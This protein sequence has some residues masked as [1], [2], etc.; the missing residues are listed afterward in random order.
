MTA[1][2]S[3]LD[4]IGERTSSERAPAV[5]AFAEAFL[6]RLSADGGADG[7]KADALCGAIVGAFEFASARGAEPIAV[8]AFT[9][10]LEEHGYELPGSVV[11]TNTE[12]WPFLVDSVSAELRA[13]GLGHPPRAAP[14][15]R[16]RA[17]RRR[18]DRRRPAPARG[19]ASRV[20]H[21]LRARAAAHGRAAG[22]GRGGAA[23]GPLRRP[24]DGQG[25]PGDGRP[26]AADGPA[27][28]RRR[29]ALRRR[30]GRRDRRLPRVAAARQLHLPRLPRVPDPRGRDL[31]RARF[32]PRDPLQHG[33]VHVRE[34]AG[35]R[36]AAARGA[37]AGGRGRPADRLQD[38]PALARPPPRA[39]GL[40]RRAPHL[41][42]GR[43]RRRGADARPVHHQ[44]LRRAGQPDAAAAPQAAPDPA[45]RGPDRGL[46]RLQGRGLAVRLVPQGRA[47]RRLD[48]RPARR[49]RRAARAAGRAGAAARPPRPRLPQRVA[50]RRA[51]A[52]ALQPR[53]AGAAAGPAA[54][55][56]R[57]RRGRLPHGAGGGRPRADPL[58]RPRL[59]GPAR[60]R[61]PRARA[62]GR[63]DDADLGRRAAGR[64]GRA[65]R[66]DAG[67][68]A[69][70]RV[71]HALPALLQG[72]DHAGAGRPRHRLLH[73]ARDA[74]RAV[75]GRAPERVR[76]ARRAHARRALQERRQGR[77]V[78]GDADARG[79]RP[80]RDRG[81]PDAAAGRRQGHLGAGLRGARPG[82]QADRPR[83]PRRARRGLH[84]RGLARRHRVRHAQPARPPRR[85]RLAPDR[86]PARLPQVPPAH[87]LALHREL[88][89]RRAGRER[90]DHPGP[91]GA[92]RAALRP[93]ARA[94]RGR[95]GGAAGADR[96]GARRGRVARPRPHPAQPARAD[97]GDAAHERLPPRAR[98][99]ELQAALGR[100]AGD[101]GARA[102]GGDLRLLGRDG[103]HPPARRPDRARR[104]P[105]VGPHGLPHRGL[106]PDAGAADQERPD[107]ARGRQG[108]LL[109]QAPPVGPD[110]AA[111]GGPAPVRRLR[112]RPARPDRQPR[113]RRGR[114]PA[115][116]ARARR[117]RHLP[118]GR[119]RQG[120]G[121]VL[122]H[123]QQ[124]RRRLRLLAR[125]RVRLRRLVR[126]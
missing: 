106:R 107:R 14:D 73:A 126:L 6:R 47:V 102:A 98:R 3:L 25:L 32:R 104:H 27:R 38:Q 99:D 88:P 112:A 96:A 93:R 95:G 69:G 29:G 100:R 83:G 70:D 19:L 2:A 44:G 55:P 11:E 63:G 4:L 15:R 35:D 67:A 110:R 9:P 50:D 116:H 1:G 114:P 33:G 10:T 84:L 89:E 109:P 90:G 82:R 118:R 79:P 30:G 76:R 26:G 68:R 39:D 56:L 80:A 86:D 97:R 71:G 52:L 40:H 103:G 92:V 48:R 16:G 37:R 62:R 34:A 7:L 28:G 81:G 23:Q 66:P 108:R 20:D 59:R 53:A 13:R 120:H 78:R 43:D 94:R 75:R 51:A 24:R 21:A 125:R 60:R 12:D 45:L 91:R 18:G 46:A 101:P 85:A 5:R 8:R 122:G 49:G 22:R 111:R 61:L 124:G 105:L 117:A 64:A 74:R 57:D 65:P 77:A 87:R 41:G 31:G 119:R 72:L 36:V 115:R 17:R 54:R 121:D 42:R 123:R 58:P 113:R